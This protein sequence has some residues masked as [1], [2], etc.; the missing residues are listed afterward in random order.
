MV[1]QLVEHGASIIEVSGSKS[2][3]YNSRG[4]AFW[5]ELVARGLPSTDY[6]SCVICELLHRSGFTLC[7]P[8]RYI[9]EGSSL[10]VFGILQRS[11]D[12]MVVT[13][14]QELISTGCL[15]KKLLLPVDV[16]GLILA[17]P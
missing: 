6:L 13:P 3:A 2:P 12:V 11:S 14:P 15:W 7:A 17:I 4:F 9:K 1:A 10:S 16:D 8:E 5:V